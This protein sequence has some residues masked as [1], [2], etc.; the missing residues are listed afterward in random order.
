MAAPNNA[1]RTKTVRLQKGSEVTHQLAIL[2]VN[3]ATH[4]DR[5]YLD[6]ILT[7]MLE[8]GAEG[9][10]GIVNEGSNN[11]YMHNT[12]RHGSG[13]HGSEGIWLNDGGLNTLGEISNLSDALLYSNF[14]TVATRPKSAWYVNTSDWGIE[15]KLVSQTWTQAVK[16]SMGTLA[17]QLHPASRYYLFRPFSFFEGNNVNI[18]AYLTNAEGEFVSDAITRTLQDSLHQVLAATRPTVCG[19][20]TTTGVLMS[21]ATRLFIQS[22]SSTSDQSTGHYIYAGSDPEEPYNTVTGQLL[23]A[24]AGIYAYLDGADNTKVIHVSALGEIR[25]ADVCIPP[26]PVIGYLAMLMNVEMDI[27]LSYLVQQTVNTTYTVSG[28]IAEF[29]GDNQV[30]PAQAFSV[31]I[32]ANTSTTNWNT[33]PTPIHQ[34]GGKFKYINVGKTPIVSGEIIIFNEI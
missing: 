2:H 1:Y 8:S 19:A 18:R 4:L 27:E 28:D 13:R 29:I 26:V 24:P 31:T 22:F 21:E 17:Q 12:S 23:A 7:V 30:S 11:F 15:I 25:R 10:I 33:K 5:F 6:G 14:I 3:K 34:Y 20:D 16:L 9:M 32:P